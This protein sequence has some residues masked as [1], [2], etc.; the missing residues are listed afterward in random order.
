MNMLIGLI[1]IFIIFVLFVY[2]NKYE[3]LTD[4][5]ANVAQLYSEG[6]MVLPKLK[7]INDLVI[8]GKNIN[9]HTDKLL[10]DQSIIMGVGG[11]DETPVPSTAHQWKLFHDKTT[12]NL[13][14]NEC[15][16]D[17]TK[18]A[19]SQWTCKDKLILNSKNG[20]I[21]LNGNVKINGTIEILKP[22]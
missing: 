7:V 16:I 20:N 21:I 2:N 14:F 22:I 8:T 17:S 19:G 12:G 5:T 10:N 3:H 9:L 6:N 11:A 15:Y 4:I 13:S 1:L 18:P